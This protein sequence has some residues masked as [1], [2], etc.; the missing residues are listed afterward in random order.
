MLYLLILASHAIKGDVR[1]LGLI[2]QVVAMMPHPSKPLPFLT[3]WVW[4]L[5]LDPLGIFLLGFPKLQGYSHILI[6]LR[7][8][9][10]NI[11]ISFKS[12]SAKL[13]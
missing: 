2:H 12:H 5:S 8:I 6:F 1:L 11:Q 10:E 13:E 7:R 4:I 9:A 3:T